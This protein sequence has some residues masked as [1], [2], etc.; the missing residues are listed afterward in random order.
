[1]KKVLF[2]C[3][4]RVRRT[5]RGG[6][7][8][9]EFLGKEDLA[10]TETPEDWISSFVEA[11]NRN[12]TEGEGLTE[13]CVDGVRKRLCDVVTA[14][15]FG[16]G[17]FES[18]VLIKLLDAGERLGIQVHPTAEFATTHFGVGYGK[19][20]CWHILATREKEDCAVYIGFKEGITKELWRSLYDRQDIDGML[21]WM[22]RI[23]V[24]AGDTV[25]VR[26]GTP[27]AIGGGCFLLEIQEPTDF[28]MRVEKITVSGEVLTPHQLHYGAGEEALFD[29]FLYNGISESEARRRYVVERRLAGVGRECLVGY[30]DTPCFAL[31]KLS[32]GG[33]IK[34]PPGFLTLVVTCGGEISVGGEAI[35][36]RRGDK[37]F[38]PYGVGDIASHGAE[39]LV[40]YPPTGNGTKPA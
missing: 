35:P 25:L 37:L 7:L 32:R 13:V 14:E 20:E 29:C 4:T 19:T 28:T 1:M 11:K 26:A 27:H 10:D 23:P 31:E 40:C 22:H 18:G 38:V 17:R 39:M 3:E 34:A 5:Y 21:A 30:S 12:Y 2:Q 16:P 24:K 8:I 9:D 33:V 36:V 15:A 6:K